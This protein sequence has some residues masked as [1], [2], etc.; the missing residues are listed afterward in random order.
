MGAEVWW[1]KISNASRLSEDVVRSVRNRES[2]L[3]SLANAP[4]AGDFA[5][6]TMESL[7]MTDSVNTLEQIAD[8]SAIPVEDLLFQEYCPPDAASM[9][10]PTPGNSKTDFLAHCDQFMLNTST[11]W[12]MAS[13]N[14][15]TEW[16]GFIKKYAS[17]C[18]N[19]R[20][21]V[22]VIQVNNDPVQ[23]VGDRN[24][25]YIAASDYISPYDYYVYYMLK[26]SEI[27]SCSTL[28][29]QYISEILTSFC[30]E[31]VVTADFMIGS[32]LDIVKTPIELY[33]RHCPEYVPQ[34]ELQSRLWR[35][36]MKVL[37][38]EIENA[39]YRIIQKNLVQIQQAL[40]Y[41]AVYGPEINEPFKLDL[42]NLLGMIKGGQITLPSKDY[43]EISDLKP[44][45][46]S[47][48]HMKPFQYNEK[49]E[50]LLS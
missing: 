8:D 2:V 1:K 37:F 50:K 39:R 36:Q 46:N 29:K 22:F 28:K 40:P 14:R 20:H 30:A 35:A 17:V 10:F 23:P 24:I 48:A 3:V 41:K 5:R 19:D 7:R 31:D 43:Q 47:L 26:T 49:L 34:E 18:N 25:M 15:V 44:I 42:G 27:S 38:P 21:A 9:Y 12:V 33:T 45:R 32:W 6:L 4:F 16:V 11:A 13:G